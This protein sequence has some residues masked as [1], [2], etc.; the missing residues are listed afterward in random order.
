M[1]RVMAIQI[2]LFALGEFLGALLARSEV[3]RSDGWVL[4][5]VVVLVAVAALV[6]A[7]GASLRRMST[8]PEATE[9]PP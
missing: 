4:A 2:V 1:G 8:Y 5:A 6:L 3:L 7:R 9:E